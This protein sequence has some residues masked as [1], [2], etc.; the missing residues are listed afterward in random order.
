MDLS[1]VADLEEAMNSSEVQEKRQA[2]ELDMISRRIR[3]QLILLNSDYSVALAEWD[4]GSELF[5][6]LGLAAKRASRLLPEVEKKVRAIVE[7]LLEDPSSPTSFILHDSIVL[8]VSILES[9]P[10]P[11]IALFVEPSRRRED[12]LGAAKRYKLTQRQIEVLGY[13]LRG[14]SAREIATALCISETTVSDH[15]KQLLL[16]TAAR[17]RA[18]MVARVLNWTERLQVPTNPQK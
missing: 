14:C 13:I 12:L 18:D 2:A 4:T 8:R 15:F 9:E 6:K 17:N 11:M 16:R 10:A 3:S 7:D 5:Q 1:C